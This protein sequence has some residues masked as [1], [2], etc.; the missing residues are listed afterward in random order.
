M[1]L[2]CNLFCYLNTFSCLYISKTSTSSAQTTEQTKD[3]AGRISKFLKSNLHFE[4]KKKKQVPS[5][6]HCYLDTFC[7]LS[8]SKNIIPSAV[9]SGHKIMFRKC[10]LYVAKNIISSVLAT[11]Q[12][13][14]QC[15]GKQEERK[16]LQSAGAM[17][18]AF[19]FTP[20]R[21]GQ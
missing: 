17:I 16:P 8:I 3:T 14:G 1:L 21:C 7:C 4:R 11:Q 20:F 18:P 5:N 15:S 9:M 2:P 10:S 19:R 13:Q 12:T 6:S